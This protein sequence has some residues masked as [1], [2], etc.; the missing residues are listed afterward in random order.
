MVDALTEI[1]ARVRIPVFY[2]SFILTPVISNASEL[3]SSIMFANKKTSS[4]ITLTF[5]QLLGAATMNNTFCLGIFLALVYF[6]ELSWTFSAEVMAIL[7]VQ[8]CVG[9]LAM[10]P[11]TPLWRSYLIA[12]LYP[13]SLILVYI[14]ENVAGWN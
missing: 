14:L 10:F 9:L 11:V 4:S 12:S 5:S 7:A 6:Q 1:S 13:A 8:L 2:V 3:I